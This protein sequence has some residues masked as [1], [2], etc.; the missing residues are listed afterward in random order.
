MDKIRVNTKEKY[1]VIFDTIDNVASHVARFGDISKVMIVSDENVAPLY[2]NRVVSSFKKGGYCVKSYILKAGEQS[3]CF[4]EYLS[5]IKEL[6]QNEFTR[7]DAIISLGGGVVG[8]VAGFCASTYMRGIA[9]IAMPTSLLAMIDS[10]IGGKCGVDFDGYKNLIGTFYQP[11]IVIVDTLTLDTLK[12]IEWKNGLGEGVKYAILASGRIASLLQN[13]VNSSS[14]KEFVWECDKYK[15]KIVSRDEKD[16]NSR[17]LL[18][19]GH[20]IGHALEAKSGYCLKHGIAV[21]KG[22]E[23][24]LNACY[25]HNEIGKKEYD[26]I[27]TMLSACGFYDSECVQIED[28]MPYISLDKKAGKDY[29]S[30]IKIKGVG[31][32]SI[33]KM[34]KNKLV[35]YLNNKG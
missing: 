29:I 22:I 10:A 17:K 25:S 34:D 20:T 4:D 9:Y 3:K 18:N 26:R 14:V 8:D 24:M 28:L 16:N 32:C 1:D 11:K 15:S 13:G 12:D 5:I 2:L 31:N 35:E 23:V 19:L 7:N 21:A 6:S 30:I 33:E 27:R